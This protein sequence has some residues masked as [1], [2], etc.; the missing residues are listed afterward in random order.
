MSFDEEWRR[1]VEAAAERKATQ[2]RLNRLDGGGEG[3][4]TTSSGELTV[5]Q[6]DLAAVG[7]AAFDL[8]TRLR[9]D[10]DHARESS[11]GAAAGLKGDFEIGGALEHVATRWQE[12]L[13]TLTDA[14]AHISNHMEYSNKAHADDEQHISSLFNS[15]SAL[16]EGYD[17]RTRRQ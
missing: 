10:G 6:K 4:V 13:R 12:Q 11:I 2:M 9:K 14:C 5:S 17:E 15:V 7:D 8:H 3:G 16:D 1:L